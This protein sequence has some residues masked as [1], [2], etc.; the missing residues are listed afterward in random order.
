MALEE[1]AVAAAAH[2]EEAPD[3][4]G[5]GLGFESG[6]EDHQASSRAACP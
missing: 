6:G 2:V 1:P 3:V 5:I 4:L